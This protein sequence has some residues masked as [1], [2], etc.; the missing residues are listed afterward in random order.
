MKYT[1]WCQ[2]DNNARVLPKVSA[3][4]P[5]VS[6]LA[7]PEKLRGEPAKTKR[8]PCKPDGPATGP[9]HSQNCTQRT[10]NAVSGLFFHLSYH[11]PSHVDPP[12]T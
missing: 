1:G 9:Q 12:L 11:R 7:P 5:M 6:K 8:R 3:L 4:L 2:N 10:C